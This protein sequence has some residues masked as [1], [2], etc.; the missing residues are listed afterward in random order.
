MDAFS[1]ELS[2]I[3]GIAFSLALGAVIL[4]SFYVNV[5]IWLQ[6]FPLEVRAVV[7]PLSAQEKRQQYLFGAWLLIFMVVGLWLSAQR[8]KAQNGGTVPFIVMFVHLYLVFMIFSLFDVIVIDYFIGSI[9]K[10]KWSV[11]AGAEHLAYLHQRLSYHLKDFWKSLIV[12][13]V[14]TLPF[15]TLTTF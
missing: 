7:P 14:F 13:I 11:I 9:L 4:T 12:G 8:L 2:L 15:A 5:R 3:D 10:P 1:I 6:D